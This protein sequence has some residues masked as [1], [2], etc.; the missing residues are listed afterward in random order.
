MKNL[1][2]CIMVFLAMNLTA[3]CNYTRFDFRF[4]YG[5]SLLGTG[6]YRMS[7]FENELNYHHNNFLAG[8]ISL[9]YGRG[10]FEVYRI[11]SFIQGNINVHIT[12]FG[13]KKRNEFRIG[14]GLSYIDIKESDITENVYEQGKIIRTEYNFNKEH[15]YGANLILEDA[16]T[17]KNRFLIGAKIFLQ[18][19]LNGNINSGMMLKLGMKI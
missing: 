15:S 9:N 8:S 5:T 7:V 19:Y 1:F 6:D 13:M 3:Q 4:G 2:L 12:P 14:T 16:Y 10:G 11:S 18:P 17:F